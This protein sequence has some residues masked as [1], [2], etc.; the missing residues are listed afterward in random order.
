VLHKAEKTRDDTTRRFDSAAF[1]Y[2]VAW[3]KENTRW[4]VNAPTFTQQETLE[5]PNPGF[6]DIANLQ[7]NR[8]IRDGRTVELAPVLRF[9]VSLQNLPFCMITREKVMIYLLFVA[10]GAR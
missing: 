6:D 1:D 3:L 2:Y 7:Y 9:V 4:E 10:R 5:L 8:L